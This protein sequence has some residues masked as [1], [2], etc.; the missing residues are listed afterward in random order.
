MSVRAIIA[1]VLLLLCS[2]VAG[3]AGAAE[4]PSAPAPS[5]T[6]AFSFRVELAPP[7]EVG[8]SEGGRR[9]F[10][11]IAGGT[12]YGPR[13]KGV[14]LPGGG[15]WQTILPGGLTKIEARYF[16]KTNDGAVIEITNPGVRTA[17]PSVTERLAKGEDVDPALYYFRTTPQ[18]R[19]GAA[20]YGWLA[21]QVFVARAIRR[22]DHV[23]I[24]YY[25]VE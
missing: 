9:R 22:P 6:Y 20:H 16:I 4:G 19:T 24:D 1:G 25:S 17:E 18:F 11:P 7:I 14:V 3:A 8:E 5:L 10:V 2:D 13:L 23:I 12:V 15:D 21:R